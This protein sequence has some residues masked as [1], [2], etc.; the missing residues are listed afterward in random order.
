MLNNIVTSRWPNKK[1][2]SNFV[3][4]RQ[5]NA[6]R[7]YDSIEVVDMW[8]IMKGQDNKTSFRIPGDFNNTELSIRM[9][10]DAQNLIL[11]AVAR[12]PNNIS[13]DLYT[14]AYTDMQWHNNGILFGDN[15]T[16]LKLTDN[17]TDVGVALSSN[18]T[19]LFLGLSQNTDDGAPGQPVELLHYDNIERVIDNINWTEFQK[20][21]KGCDSS[22]SRNHLR[23]SSNG[24]MLMFVILPL[25]SSDGCI[26]V[27]EKITEDTSRASYKWQKRG[28]VVKGVRTSGQ[29]YLLSIS[30]DGLTFVVGLDR[31]PNK[32]QDKMSGDLIIYEFDDSLSLWTPTQASL[33]NYSSI[34]G[35]QLLDS[36]RMVVALEGLKGYDLAVY[37]KTNSTS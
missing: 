35:L 18:D 28:N 11:S 16:D 22:G 20:G 13:I 33:G 26:V 8:S 23:L 6:T 12:H 32:S 15:S 14:L 25:N 34:E 19:V 21:D 29:T 9:S 7:G 30:N 1:R 27:F 24:R 17:Y 36:E 31:G 3:T 5:P 37:A 4:A 10:N 2:K